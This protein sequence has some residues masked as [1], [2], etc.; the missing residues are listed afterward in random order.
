MLMQGSFSEL[1]WR[2][3]VERTHEMTRGTV[4]KDT[5]LAPTCQRMSTFKVKYYKCPHT[6]TSTYKWK[7][8]SH[9]HTGLLTTNTGC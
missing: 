2:L 9:F 4:G 6:L 3:Q 1:R 8:V 5:S 7:K